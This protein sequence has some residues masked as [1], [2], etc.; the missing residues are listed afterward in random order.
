[1][2]RSDDTNAGPSHVPSAKPSATAVGRPAPKQQPSAA[3]G[4]P[5]PAAAGSSRTTQTGV[6]KAEATARSG[7]GQP[8]VPPGLSCL[9]RYYAGEPKFDSKTGWVLELSSGALPWDDG[10]HDKTLDEL[11]D[12]PD[13]SDVFAYPYD[14]GKPLDGPAKGD[15]GR[16]RVD[17][18]L[19]AK[20][21][22]D[23]A[24]IESNLETVL[25][26]GKRVQVH[27]RI[28]AALTA[29]SRRL[30]PLLKQPEY[31]RYFANLGGTYNFRK[32]EGTKRLSAHSYGIAIDLDTRFSSYWRWEKAEVPSKVVPL[33]IV[34]AF[35]EEGFVWGG[36]WIHFDTMHF[37][38]R[39]EIIDSSCFNGSR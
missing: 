23:K 25:F 8:Q 13:L 16:V 6:P 1:M 22:K 34:K 15:P 20:Y 17:D 38:Y 5:N 30:E 9:A 2:S 28:A 29:V 37:E 33:P 31:A 10:K 32:I 3:S 12:K 35:E 26:A 18:L 7:A 4:A 24:A 36:R 19:F 39:P 11:L 27:K 14:K 21:G